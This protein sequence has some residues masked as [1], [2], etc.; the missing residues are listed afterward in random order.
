MSQRAIP[1]GHSSMQT[2]A[3]SA[4]VSNFID[5][6]EQLANARREW[7]PHVTAE[8]AKTITFIKQCAALYSRTLHNPAVQIAQPPDAIINKT[9]KTTDDVDENFNRHQLTLSNIGVRVQ[10]DI[11]LRLILNDI[12]RLSAVLQLAV[13]AGNQ[14]TSWSEPFDKIFFDKRD[15]NDHIWDVQTVQYS[16]ANYLHFT[17][18]FFTTCGNVG[19]ISRKHPNGRQNNICAY[20][21]AFNKQAS[22]EMLN[23]LSNK[24]RDIINTPGPNCVPQQVSAHSDHVRFH[25]YSCVSGVGNTA[26]EVY[27]ACK[28]VFT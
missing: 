22:F 14:I 10:H 25:R 4:E 5:F 13:P 2:N 28:K 1:E 21:F 7:D 9:Q 3:S 18:V 6:V 12:N 11:K 27:E 17:H 8:M 26:F 19:Y 24:I 23:S 20:I 16:P 15:D